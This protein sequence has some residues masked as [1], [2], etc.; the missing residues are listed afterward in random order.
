MTEMV[1]INKNQVLDTRIADFKHTRVLEDG[2]ER[3]GLGRGFLLYGGR[4]TVN[5]CLLKNAGIF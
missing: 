2:A 5:R 3:D 4:G 1:E